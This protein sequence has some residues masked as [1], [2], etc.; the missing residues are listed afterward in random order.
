MALVIKPIQLTVI[1]L[2]LVL[3][4]LS[5]FNNLNNLSLA[6]STVIIGLIYL[7]INSLIIGNWLFIKNSWPCKFILGLLFVLMIAGLTGTIFFYLSYIGI[8]SFVASLLIIYAMSFF[9]LKKHHLAFKLEKFWNDW[10]LKQI[11]LTLVYLILTAACFYL[12]FKARTNESL[13]S[14]WEAVSSNIFFLYFFASLILLAIIKFSKNNFPL[15]LISLH[16]FLTF[17]AAWLVYGVG[18]DYDPFIHR[19]NLELILQNGTLLPKPFYYIGQYSLIIFLHNLLQISLENLDKILV[20]LMSA[21]YLPA[22]I[23]YTFKN[24]FKARDNLNLLVILT[25]LIFPLNFIVTTPQSLANLFFLITVIFSLYYI[26]NPRVSIIPLALLGLTT[27]IIH[28]LA[29][30]PLIFFLAMAYFYKSRKPKIRLSSGF[31]KSIVAEL[32]IIGSFILP[33]AFL[34]NSLTLSQLKVSLQSDW[35]ANLSS[36]FYDLN[37]DIYYRAYISLPDLIYTFGKNIYLILV[38]LFIVGLVFVFKHKKLKNFGIYLLGFIMV[39]LNFIF[40][41]STI[42]FFSLVSYEQIT[43][44]LRALEL[45]LYLLAPFIIIGLYLLFKKISRQ[46]KS[47]TLLIIILLALALSFSFYLRY[48]RVDKIEEDHGY[49]TSIHDLKTVNLIEDLSGNRPHIV[50]AN[51]SISAAAIKELKFK[52]YY[53]GYF[54]YPVPTGGRLYSLYEDLAYGKQKTEEVIATVRLLTGVN[55]IYFVIND[56]WSGFA[57]KVSLEKELADKW[58]SISDRNFIFLYQN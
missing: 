27:L 35:L 41:R 44:P 16:Y 20:P 38:A 28:P 21:V 40:L 45:S 50:L 14:P 47:L 7:L 23:F 12:F 10:D 17:S 9:I 1:S 2:I 57:D 56:Y 54:F 34:V 24:N 51:Q 11:L 22:I 52:D 36:S 58:Y 13:R 48:P 55:D 42:S 8:F 32:L 37:P 43:Y 15:F 25:L 33:A 18:F 6:V 3:L 5:L 4:Q 19:T 39:F 46:S 31:R 26:N 29:G 30:L 49:S 53:N